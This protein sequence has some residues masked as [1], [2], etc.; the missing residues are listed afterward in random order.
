MTPVMMARQAPTISVLKPHMELLPLHQ[1]SEDVA[2]C[3]CTTARSPRARHPRVLKVLEELSVPVHCADR[4]QHGR[5]GGGIYARPAR[6]E[7]AVKAASLTLSADEVA[8]LKI[9]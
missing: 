4:H 7:E 1:H 9:G 8:A 5:R 6:I 2:G 3:P